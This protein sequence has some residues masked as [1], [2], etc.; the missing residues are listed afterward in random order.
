[1]NECL[2]CGEDV[3]EGQYR[4]SEGYCEA[5]EYISISQA[6][7]RLKVSRTSID[8]L[9]ASGRLRK[10]KPLQAVLIRRMDVEKMLRG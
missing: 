9:L 5:C 2:Y 6:A 10:I 3:P 8:R 7:T 1:M 4:R